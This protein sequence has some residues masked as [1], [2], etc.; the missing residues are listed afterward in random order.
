VFSDYFCSW[1]K[2]RNFLKKK[3]KKKKKMEKK[4]KNKKKLNKN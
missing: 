2:I 1:N 4:E 3:K